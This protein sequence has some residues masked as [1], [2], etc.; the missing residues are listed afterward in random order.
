MRLDKYLTNQGIGSRSQVKALIKSK[1]VFVN[2]VL[3]NKPE[4]HIDENNDIVSLDGVNLEYN[5]FYYYMLN[6]PPGVLTAVKD[7]NY[8][9]V[10]DIMDVTPKEGLFPVGRLDKDTEGLLLITNDGE[11]S[12]NLLSPKKHVNKTYYVELNGE[13]IDSD[14]D[15]FAKGLDIGEKNITKPAKLEI[16]SGRNRAYITITEGKY[17]QVKR[18]FQA[19]GLTVTFLKR[20]SMGSLILDKNLKS[21]GYRKLTEEEISNLKSN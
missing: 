21:G 1:K 3:E 13:L 7:N 10:M 4:R 18:M 20:I 17:H 6:K 12:H 15:L 5:K 16:L 8:K 9:T 11:L 14:I 2:N 19:I